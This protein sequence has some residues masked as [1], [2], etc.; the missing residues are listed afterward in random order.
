MDV[1]VIPLLAFAI[2]LL[3]PAEAPPAPKPDRVTLL[4]A[5]DGTVGAVVVAPIG[6]NEQRL[7][8]PYASVETTKGVARLTAADPA[9]V[10]RRYG[11]ILTGQPPRPI[12]L[13]VL[14]QEWRRY[15]RG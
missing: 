4:P 7:D 3:A 5:P 1:L 2:Y 13:T 6:G 8:T 10:Q 9:D 15:T 12:S 11:E 14:L